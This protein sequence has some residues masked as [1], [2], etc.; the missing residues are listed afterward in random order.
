MFVSM[1]SFWKQ[2]VFIGKKWDKQPINPLCCYVKE[3][4]F[5]FITKMLMV[6]EISI[7][8]E[9]HNIELSNINYVIIS[10]WNEGCT[11]KVCYWASFDG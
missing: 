5:K 3:C 11:K 8:L 9:F 1:S 7:A 2:F 6:K 4:D 10:P